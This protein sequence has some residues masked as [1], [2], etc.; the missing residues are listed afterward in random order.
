MVCGGLQKSEI[1]RLVRENAELRNRLDPSRVADEWDV[2]GDLRGVSRDEE[3]PEKWI[4]THR[5]DD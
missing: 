2:L 3:A 4:P 1:V 5:G